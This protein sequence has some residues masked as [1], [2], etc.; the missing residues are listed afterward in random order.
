ML[1]VALAVSLFNT[2]GANSFFYSISITL[3]LEKKT[4]FSNLKKGFERQN[5]VLK[6]IGWWNRMVTLWKIDDLPNSKSP[7]I[8]LVKPRSLR[9]Q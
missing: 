8:T 3:D 5:N 6:E 9:L 1:K 7:I 4:W 2:M